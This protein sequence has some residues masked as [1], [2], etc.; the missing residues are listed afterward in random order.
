MN[1][2]IGKLLEHK[3]TVLLV[4]G[5]L[6]LGLSIAGCDDQNK[7]KISYS[8]QPDASSGWLAGA[9]S[10]PTPKTLHAMARIFAS[11]GR[12]AEAS[13]VLNKVI[14]EHPK[15]LPT[16]V[17][18]A[19]IHMRARQVDPA[20]EVLTK[21]LKV[22][23]DE[24]IL[25]NNIGM[26]WLLNKQYDRALKMFSKASAAEPNDARYRANMAVALGLAGRYDEALAVYKQVLGAADAHFNLAVLC[27]A[28]GD[29]ARAEQE[30]ALY[31]EL[32]AIEAENPKE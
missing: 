1:A 24:P 6:G 2:S 28:R 18:L 20:I 10:P 19:E 9:E 14:E 11:Q 25:L 31:E 15:F 30:Y 21:G 12:E 22:A 17:E 16:Y 32:K 13:F 27:E 7:E 29:K 4:V 26:C 23:P 3:V 8:Q 5:L